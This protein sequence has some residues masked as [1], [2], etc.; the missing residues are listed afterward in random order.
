MDAFATCL[1]IARAERERLQRGCDEYKDATGGVPPT[2]HSAMRAAQRI[3]DAIM[4]AQQADTKQ[5]P[6]PEAK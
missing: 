6:A 5:A 2:L 4:A 3:E 1:D